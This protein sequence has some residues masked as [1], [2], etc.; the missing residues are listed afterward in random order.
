MYL[1]PH[2]SQAM[3]TVVSRG[4]LAADSSSSTRSRMATHASQIWLKRQRCHAEGSTNGPPVVTRDSYE[5]PEDAQVRVVSVRL[6]IS[7]RP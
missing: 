1:K 6:Y 2:V 7:C 3:Q 5:V 4:M